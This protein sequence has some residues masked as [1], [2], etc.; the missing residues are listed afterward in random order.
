MLLILQPRRAGP[1]MR[2]P[3]ALFQSRPECAETESR[4]GPA[5]TCSAPAIFPRRMM[6]QIAFTAA[7][8]DWRPLRLSG[9]LRLGIVKARR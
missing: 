9:F 3:P 2:T 8:T 7:S 4:S 6:S 1:G 5:Q